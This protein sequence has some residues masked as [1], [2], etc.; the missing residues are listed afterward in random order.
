MNSAMKHLKQQI[1]DAVSASLTSLSFPEKDFS[2]APPKNPEFGDLSTNVS[3]LLTRDLKKPPL[4]IAQSIADELNKELPH[5]ISEISVTPPGFINFKVTESFYQSKV[6][7]ILDAGDSFGKGSHGD[8]KT[9][10]VEFVSANPTG[11]LTVGHGRNAVLGDTVSSILEWHGFE[12]TREYYFNDAGRQMRIL[13]QSVEA[14]Y[15]EILGQDVEFPQEGYQG[16]YIKDIAQSIM[17]EQG[18]DLPTSDPSFKEKAEESIFEDIKKSLLNLGIHFD[19][20]TNEKTFYDN[21]EIDKFLGELQDK[22]LIYEKDGATWFKATALGKDQDRVYIKSTGEPTYRVPDT[23][24]H[25]DKINRGF[26]L[27]VD[28]FGADHTDSYPDVLLALESLGLKTDHIRVL[29]YQFVTL[30]RGGEKIKMST[31]KANYVTMDELINEVGPDVVRYF[32]IMRSMNTHL[33]FDL[34]LATDQSDKNPVF[35]LQYAH[36]RICNIIKHGQESGLELTQDFDSSL[37]SHP[38]EINLIRYMVRFPEI[39]D[40]A[41][42][43]LEPQIIANML[44]ELATRFHKFYGQCHVITEDRALSNARLALITAVKI[45]MGNGLKILGLSAPERM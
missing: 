11:P 42:E 44:Q 21:G 43:N 9:A 36:A 4:E 3:L 18:S 2:L 7:T 45:I 26:D 24:Y 16:S 32:F 39:M 41:Y 15:F 13:G 6:K 12:V 14:R 23:A 40:L 33:D 35:Y 27:I 17:D 30:L 8:G 20:F 25:R 34:E 37:L 29:L 22:D 31:R 1:T 5:H 28:I 10:N 19:Q 38:D